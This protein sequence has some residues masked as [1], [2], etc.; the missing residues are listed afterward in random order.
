[1]D[2]YDDR[3]LGF[4]ESPD[5]KIH[6]RGVDSWVI[7]RTDEDGLDRVVC[8]CIHT[9]TDRGK[10]SF[11]VLLVHDSSGV[12]KCNLIANPIRFVAQNNQYGTRFR[13]F[14]YPEQ[15]TEESGLPIGEQ[16]FGRAHP[17]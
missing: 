6:Q 2:R 3:T 17:T 7:D 11:P 8:H 1:M 15:V 5:E 13:R 14:E 4:F 12:T 9:D 10:H 16:G